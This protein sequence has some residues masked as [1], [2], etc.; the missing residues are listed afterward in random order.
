MG[1]ACAVFFILP[2]RPGGQGLL[3]YAYMYI[4]V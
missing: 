1:G 3:F 2:A 4:Y